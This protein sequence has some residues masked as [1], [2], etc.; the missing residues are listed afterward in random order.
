MSLGVHD[1]SS[2]TFAGSRHAVQF[3]ENDDF[4]CRCVTSFV[5]NGLQANEPV[6]LVATE[7]HREKFA[8]QFRILGIDPKDPRIIMLDARTTLD[9]FLNGNVLNEE[10]FRMTLGGTLERLSGGGRARVRAYGEMVDLLWRDGNPAG[11]IELEEMWNGLAGLYSFSLLCSYPMGNFY[12]EAHGAAFNEICSAHSHVTPTEKFEPASSDDR[13]REIAILQQRALSLEN[14]IE[15]RKELENALRQSLRAKDE[16][17]ATLSHELRTP[18]TA[19]IGWARMLEAG[20]VDP[21]LVTTAI[22]T[23]DRCARA[24]ASLIDDLLDISRII[25]GKF[26][27]RADVVDLAGIAR[28]AVDTLRL[29]ADARNITIDLHIPIGPTMVNG[30]ATRLQQIVW[31]LLSNAM[32]FSKNGT[33][34][35][36]EV[37]HDDTNALLTI[38]D[39]GRG[40]AA[41]LL[42]HVFEPFRQGDS[43]S[44]RSHGGLGL[45]LAIVKHVTEMHGGTVLATSDGPDRGATFVV[46]LP[47]A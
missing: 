23:I 17:L 19:I 6:V 11:A 16:F 2:P 36:I 29:A 3:Y 33:R 44:T 1:W 20:V 31:N 41:E 8:A 30:D 5:V 15:L 18:L 38:R 9:S 47:R 22:G 43:S 21:T 26:S 25:T 12:K 27:L 4:L 7:A 24:Q 42:P 28:G 14:E 34:V 35:T 46:T 45:G 39:E 13:A 37:M 40:I 10:R 32:K